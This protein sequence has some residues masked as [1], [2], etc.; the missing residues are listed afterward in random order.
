MATCKRKEKNLSKGRW[1]LVD[2]IINFIKS[3]NPAEA[4]SELMKMN[5]VDIATFLEEVDRI[6]LVVLFRILP[7]DTAA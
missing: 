6:D 3:G 2:K 7:K 5:V 4:R 1:V